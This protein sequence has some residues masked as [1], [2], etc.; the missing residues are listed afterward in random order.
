MA[1]RPPPAVTAPIPVVPRAAQ[2]LTP[3]APGAT[4]PGPRRLEDFR[5]QR[6]EAPADRQA[7]AGA[8][9]RDQNA[10]AGQQIAL[11]HQILMS[12]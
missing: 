7:D 3:I 6:Q 11:E 9:A 4:A 5:A 8:A 10:L 2:A 12:K 1:R